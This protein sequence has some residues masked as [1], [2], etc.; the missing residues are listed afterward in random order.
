VLGASFDTPQDNRAFAEEHGYGGR[1][2]CDVDRMVGEAYGTARPPGE[3]YAEYA[4]RRTF[5]IDPAGRIA[6][7]YQVKDIPAHPGHLLEDL[8]ALGAARG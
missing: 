2:L 3:Q 8:R 6:R 4:R 7:I 1:L 5:L